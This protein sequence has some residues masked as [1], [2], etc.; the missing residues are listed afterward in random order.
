MHNAT[1]GNVDVV[2]MNTPAAQ[3]A[4]NKTLIDSLEKHWSRCQSARKTP[5][6]TQE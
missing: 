2:V 5:T 6:R 3:K 1:L 4:D